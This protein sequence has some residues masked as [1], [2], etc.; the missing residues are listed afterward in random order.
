MG[1]VKKM[2]GQINIICDYVMVK[3]DD[4]FNR[5]LGV[6]TDEN[7]KEHQ[8]LVDSR[9]RPEH[10]VKVSAEVIA[11]PGYLSG[12]DSPVYEKYPG[13]PR[14]R[15]YRGN[16]EIQKIINGIAKQYRKLPDKQV[17][18]SCGGYTPK[19]VTHQGLDV[20]VL[21]GDKVYFHY[22]TLL[23]EENYM[24]RDA[25]GRMVYKVQY[26]QL[27]CRVRD[28]QIY[29]LNGNVLVDEFYDE[30][31]ENVEVGDHSIRAKVKSGLVVQIG[32]KP[33]YLTGVLRYIGS[34]VGEQTRKTCAPGEL[35]MFR[36]SSEFK[37]TIEGHEYYVMKQWDIVAKV[38]RVDKETDELLSMYAQVE[39]NNLLPVGDYLLIEPE[40][41]DF[42]PGV[43][44]RI[45][46]PSNP[47]QE[48]NKGELFVLT[49]IYSHE[50]TN[51]L[52]KHGI[53]T[54]ISGG[55][56]NDGRFTGKRVAYGKGTFYL[57]LKEYKKVLVRYG[58]VFG[59]FLEEEIISDVEQSIRT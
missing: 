13:M 14:P 10:H 38:L 28:G 23:Q 30:D 12:K 20:E 54:V 47:N 58:D 5:F 22:A 45:Y 2:H 29:M 44:K 11:V 51:K 37:N 9:W 24:Y 49:G 42:M 19:N 53:G 52:L 3:I 1:K 33:K 7:G 25:D 35:I 59:E 39:V 32:E 48:F 15:A 8:L 36:P 4:E 56:L 46:D 50:K 6:V 18:Y 31:L 34:P 26:S 17:P 21:P 57:Y 41:V 43:K 55:E 16:D 40:E 27:F